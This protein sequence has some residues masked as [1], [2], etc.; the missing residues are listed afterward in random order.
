M[1]AGIHAGDDGLLGADGSRGNVVGPQPDGSLTARVQGRAIGG[2]GKAVV[3]LHVADEGL[4]AVDA[5]IVA[6]GVHRDT[7]AGLRHQHVPVGIEYHRPRSLQPARDLHHRPPR[8]HGTGEPH[9]GHPGAAR[10]HR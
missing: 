7:L 4:R 8:G 2:Q 9:V 3:Q 10:G 1:N 6:E 5:P